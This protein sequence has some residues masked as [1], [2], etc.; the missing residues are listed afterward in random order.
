MYFFKTNGVSACKIQDLF[1]TW[2]HTLIKSVTIHNV[3]ECWFEFHSGFQNR[4]DLVE[5]SVAP[6]LLWL[7]KEEASTGTSSL[8]CRHWYLEHT[9]FQT[10][11]GAEDLVALPT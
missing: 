1:R 9:L 5:H 3:I 7:R 10:E 4:C 11:P 8:D 2:I 6:L